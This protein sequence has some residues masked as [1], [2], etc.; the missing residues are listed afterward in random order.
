MHAE[1]EYKQITYH[2]L[3][4]PGDSQPSDYEPPFFRA[5]SDEEK[6]FWSHAPLKLKVGGVDS[7]YFAMSLKVYI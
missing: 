3:L 1:S 4:G 5:C 2:N 7:K 6:L